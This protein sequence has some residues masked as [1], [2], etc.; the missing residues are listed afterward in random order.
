ML[1]FPDTNSEVT[2]QTCYFPFRYRLMTAYSKSVSS[3]QKH[4]VWEDYW[5]GNSLTISAVSNMPVT[6]QDDISEVGRCFSGLMSD[7]TNT[8]VPLRE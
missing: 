4:A 5:L 8:V 7:Y 2:K 6:R 1:N 3:L